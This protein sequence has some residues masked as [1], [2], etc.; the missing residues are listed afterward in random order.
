[1]KYLTWQN[2]YV[3]LTLLLQNEDL[4]SRKILV[5]SKKSLTATKLRSDMVFMVGLQS[6]LQFYSF[7]QFFAN[8]KNVTNMRF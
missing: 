1:M 6:L 3:N 4:R 5:H 2:F 8:C 7:L